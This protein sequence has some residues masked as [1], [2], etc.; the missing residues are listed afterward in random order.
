MTIA[1]A[2]DLVSMAFAGTAGRL[3]PAAP[4][5]QFLFCRRR[6]YHKVSNDAKGRR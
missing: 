4:P 6:E 2:W 3:M 1:P 5:A